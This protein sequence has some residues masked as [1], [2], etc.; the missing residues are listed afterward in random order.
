LAFTRCGGWDGVALKI[1]DDRSPEEMRRLARGECDGRMTARLYALA[2]A[3][4]GM[5]PAEA[6]RLA[7]MERQALRDAVVRYNAED[8][9]GLHRLGF[10]RQKTWPA[11]PELDERAQRRFQK[12]GRAPP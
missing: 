9:A 4:G 11:H 5:R 1:K 2:N 6:A 3:L 12:R 8:L 10:S 7:G